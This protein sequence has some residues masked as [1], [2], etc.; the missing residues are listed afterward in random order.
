MELNNV[1]LYRI[2]HIENIPHILRYG[3]THKDS[4]NNNP[5][6]K[7]IGD[8][9]LI[10]TRSKKKVNIDNGEFNPNNVIVSITLGDFISFNFGICNLN[11][12]PPNSISWFIK[13]ILLTLLTVCSL[14]LWFID[15]KIRQFTPN[16][17][18]GSY[19]YCIARKI[20]GGEV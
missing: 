8:L 3:I 1:I 7:N 15:D 20:T 18:T 13:K 11:G 5:D 19:I 10:E 17:F 2:T 6:Y 9:S 14:I 16:K 12:I 4:I